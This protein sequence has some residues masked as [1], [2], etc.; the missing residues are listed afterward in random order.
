MR[1]TGPAKDIYFYCLTGSPK[2]NVWK[3]REN[4]HQSDQIDA[5][6]PHRCGAVLSRKDANLVTLPHHHHSRK[7]IRNARVIKSAIIQLM[8]AFLLLHPWH[9]ISGIQDM[10]DQVYHYYYTADHQNNRPSVTLT[11]LSTKKGGEDLC[12]CF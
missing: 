2:K 7:K 8:L 3:E 6:S 11:R 1:G 9:K 4:F 10:K 5:F 12:L